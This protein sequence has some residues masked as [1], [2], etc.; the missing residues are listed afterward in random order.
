MLKDTTR[1]T[2]IISYVSALL[3]VC[4]LVAQ[5]LP[6]WSYTDELLQ[7]NK[8]KSDKKVSLCFS[9]TSNSNPDYAGVY[10]V[11]LP[12]K[13]GDDIK[14]LVDAKTPQ[15]SCTVGIRFYAD[16]VEVSDTNYMAEQTATST[17][18]GWATLA[19]RGVAPEGAN[20]VRIWLWA[21]DGKE[22]TN[23]YFDNVIV[24]SSGQP[25]V[26][27]LM[28]DY[29][30]SFEETEENS[31][32]IAYWYIDQEQ[33]TA[34][35]AG[36]IALPKHHTGLS[37]K[38][39]PYVEQELRNTVP[40]PNNITEQAYT[41]ALQ[42]AVPNTV[43]TTGLL[44]LL[45]AGFG[46]YITAVKASKAWTALLPFAAGIVGVCQYLGNS[47][48]QLGANWQIHLAICIAALVVSA[49]NIGFFVMGLI[50]KKKA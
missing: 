19:L 12:V 31:K 37:A 47:L 42:L 15:G 16:D 32:Q 35:I 24:T 20:F 8:Q 48:Y 33:P 17:D 29:N 1:L 14:A 39:Y 36:Y 9:K 22:V 46:L 4:I 3:M 23:H 11:A 7:H 10:S 43:S 44:I 50:K 45:L 6:F 40:R 2:K 25:G 49:V 18:S 13:A 34:S 41:N 30:Y 27:N 5:F 38:F 21:E 28:A 26:E